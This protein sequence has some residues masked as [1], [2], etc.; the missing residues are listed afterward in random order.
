MESFVNSLVVALGATEDA[1]VLLAILFIGRAYYRYTT[2]VNLE[3][4]IVARDNPAMGVALAGFLVGLA[5]AAS[6]GLFS[7]GTHFEKIMMVFGIGFVSMILMRISLVINDKLILSK[8]SN[9]EE[10]VR[11]K[12]LGVGFIEAGGCIATGLMINGVMSGKADSIQE[13]LMYGA[14]YWMIGQF[15]LV[16]GAFLFRPTCGFDFDATLEND[17]NAAAGLSF[18]GFIVGIGMIIKASLYGVSTAVL[19]ELATIATFSSIGFLLLIFAKKWLDKVLLP[20]VV[21]TRELDKDKNMG[22]GALSAA[23]YVCIA[24]LFASSISPATTASLFADAIDE[25]AV[26]V[27]A[28]AEVKTETTET[29]PIAKPAS[30][31][32]AAPATK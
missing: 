17:N 6:G 11:D 23:G 25:A 32:D 27:I 14:I 20:T 21:M 5:I 3:E 4:E 1:L 2:K 16:V 7:A 15:A 8:F 24:L 18:A 22:A 29:V 31:P 10:I 26:P 19:P 30:V 13:K 28:P 12:N 9:I